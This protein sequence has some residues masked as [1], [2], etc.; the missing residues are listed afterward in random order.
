[1]LPRSADWSAASVATIDAAALQRQLE[2]VYDGADVRTAARVNR[3][4]G[5]TITRRSPAADR[6]GDTGPTLTLLVDSDG[7]VES[8]TDEMVSDWHALPRMVSPSLSVDIVRSGQVVDKSDV[9]LV[10]IG[11]VITVDGLPLSAPWT[12]RDMQVRRITDRVD[13]TGWQR[14]FTVV[15]APDLIDVFRVGDALDGPKVLGW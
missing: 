4:A 7:Q 8:L 11:D 13:T 9:L 2:F 1:M 6:H 12:S 14:T 3:P 10:E 15:D 5:P